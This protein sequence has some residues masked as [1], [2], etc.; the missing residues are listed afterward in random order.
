MIV[1]EAH[2]HSFI[3]SCVS[4]FAV[5]IVSLVI[6]YAE[7]NNYGMILWVI[8]SDLVL[9]IIVLDSSFLNYSVIIA[10]NASICITTLNLMMIS[11]KLNKLDRCVAFCICT[12]LLMQMMIFNSI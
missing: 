6:I 1:D 12:L 11:N 3:A 8:L 2:Y 9:M 4:L 5:Q 7:Y 10:L